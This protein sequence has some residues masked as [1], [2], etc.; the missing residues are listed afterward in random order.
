HV[1]LFDGKSGELLCLMRADFLGQ[2]RTGAASAVATR[3]MA[4]AD[5]QTV[6]VFGSGK[7]ARTQLLAVA[8]GRPLTKVS[9]F[10]PSEEHR[11]RFADAMER[12]LGIPVEPVAQPQFAATNQDIVITATTSREPVLH[13]DWLTPGTHLN[14]IG[15]NFLGKSE[16][17]VAT[18]RRCAVI[19]V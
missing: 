13:G 8:K 16:I 15:S 14:V 1:G 18:I 4:R 7:Q 17:D 2:V 9:G 19:A 12:E 10:S 3:S 6:G 5:A 11:R